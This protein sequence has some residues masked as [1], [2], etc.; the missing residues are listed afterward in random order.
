MPAGRD[1][2]TTR[3]A[4]D[5]YL[6][7]RRAELRPETLRSIRSG[8]EI[9]LDW[10]DEANV[11]TMNE[12]TG[13]HLLEFKTWRKTTGDLALVSLNGNLAI[14]RRFLRFCEQIDAV[15]EDF[16]KKVP[17]PNVPPEAEV[18]KEVP[19]SEEVEM[20]RSYISTF[21]YASRQHIEFELVAEIGLR[22]GAVRAIDLDDFDADELAIHLRH[23]PGS[24]EKP[25][26]PLKNGTGG[27][28]IINLPSEFR[29]VID[30]YV[31]HN[32]HDVVDAFDRE[33]LL[34]TTHGRVQTTTVR[35]DFYKLTRPCEY[36]NECPHGRDLDEC[37][38]RKSANAS[39]CPSSFS[40]HPVRKWSIM[41][42]LDA[43]VPRELLSDRVD[44]SVPVLEK[45][46]DQRSEQRKSR[47]RRKELA[48]LLPKYSDE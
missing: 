2:L 23:R 15:E 44:V 24:P 33:P 35:R 7:D 28:R 14:L 17:L 48:D 21:D 12:L 31:T 29:D 4:V 36:T 30:A 27:E 1:P 20:I 3:D 5:W 19:D 22:L 40:T 43:G 16:S 37:D 18:R 9:F 25:G 42:Q 47:R 8:L 32:R 39:K 45:H 41:N 10:T 38:A 34:T 26:T 6:Y 46:Y 11:E 13:R